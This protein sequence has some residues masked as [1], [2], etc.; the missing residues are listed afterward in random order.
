MKKE[1]EIIKQM[2]DHSDFFKLLNT[3]PEKWGLKDLDKIFPQANKS[4]VAGSIIGYGANDISVD[5]WYFQDIQEFWF[6]CYPLGIQ[7]D[8]FKLK[9][10]KNIIKL[11]N[12]PKIKE[13]ISFI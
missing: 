9:T 5:L 3:F 8:N 10:L 2:C 7:S 1:Y 6:E 11:A 12:E 4:M 13:I